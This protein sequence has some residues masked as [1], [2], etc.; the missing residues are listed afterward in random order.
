MST[1]SGK[2]YSYPDAKL[3]YQWKKKMDPHEVQLVESRIGDLLVSRGYP[4][5]GLPRIT[6]NP[7]ELLQL[8]VKNR[9]GRVQ[10]KRNELGTALWL[11]DI[12]ARRSPIKP[13]RDNVKRRIN[14]IVNDNVK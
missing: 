10:Y 12:I 5:S 13:W 2:T 4:L 3:S 14:K 8:R 1:E 11:E 6:P 9:I 7:L